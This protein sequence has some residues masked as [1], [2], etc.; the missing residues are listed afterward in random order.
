MCAH[1]V[2][3]RGWPER[4]VGWGTPLRVGGARGGADRAPAPTWGHREVHIDP[5]H[6]PAE[7]VF[8]S[9]HEWS[10]Q[11][12]ARGAFLPSAAYVPETPLVALLVERVLQVADA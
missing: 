10:R 9:D 11:N 5:G 6:G 1:L 8:D 2:R 4:P 12:D 3:A 7:A